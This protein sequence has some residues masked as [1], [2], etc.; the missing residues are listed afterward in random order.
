MNRHERSSPPVHPEAL[1]IVKPPGPLRLPVMGQ[2][3][4]NP[5]LPFSVTGPLKLQ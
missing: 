4:M 2:L 1:R 3:P 5:A